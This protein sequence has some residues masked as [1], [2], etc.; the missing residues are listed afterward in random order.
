[1]RTVVADHA[2][3]WGKGDGD[4]G[5]VTAAALPAVSAIKRRLSV[6]SASRKFAAH[7]ALAIASAAFNRQTMRGFRRRRN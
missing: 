5:A 7:I 4:G 3:V 2:V 1:M 6:N